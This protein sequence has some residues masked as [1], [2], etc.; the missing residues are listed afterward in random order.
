MLQSGVD[1]AFVL[2]PSAKWRISWNLPVSSVKPVQSAG[3]PDVN[4]YDG[5]QLCGRARVGI[6]S[7][8]YVDPQIPMSPGNTAQSNNTIGSFSSLITCVVNI[9]LAAVSLLS[10]V[11]RERCSV[12][13]H[14]SCFCGYARVRVRLY[15]RRG[16][17]ERQ[18][19]AGGAAS[20]LSC[21]SVTWASTSGGEAAAPRL[22]KAPYSCHEIR[23]EKP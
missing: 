9:L 6:V 19:A 7:V 13:L 18:T 17:K 4:E 15:E 5:Q 21:G 11:F 8:G 14:F 3:Y 20:S 2:P 23:R 10:P 16:K 12:S 22:E 1:A